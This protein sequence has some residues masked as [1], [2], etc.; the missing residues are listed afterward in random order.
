MALLVYTLLRM[1]LVVAAGGVLYLAGMRGLLL[2]VMAVVV[3]A[4][5]SYLLLKGPRERAAGTL[6]GLAERRP[7]RERADA[8]AQAEDAVLDA[9]AEP[10]GQTEDGTER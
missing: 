2:V 4:M 9:S 10:E 8:D 6:Q 1:L 5:L 3:G 7:E